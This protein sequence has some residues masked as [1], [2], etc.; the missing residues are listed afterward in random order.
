MNVL[1]IP[2]LLLTAMALA[3]LLVPL[4][5]PVR[6][7]PADRGGLD[8]AVF[9]DQLA[10]V[11]QDLE[12]GLLSPAEAE[13]MRLELQRRLLSAAST[14]GKDGRTGAPARADRGVAAA[15]AVLVP[16]GAFLLYFV[17][18][19]PGMR[20]H[21]LAG[22]ASPDATRQAATMEGAIAKLAKHLETHP[23]NLEGWLL[24]G[25][26]HAS[27]DRFAD[28]AKAYAEARK[29]A[30]NDAD[31][32]VELAEARLIASGEEF[33]REVHDLFVGAVKS[34]PRNTK[35]RFYLGMEMAQ[36]GDAPGALQAWTD[37]V[38][39]SPEEAPWLEIVNARITQLAGESGID[40]STLQPSA[41]ARELRAS[42]PPE[43]PTVEGPDMTPAERT[44]LVRASIGPLEQHLS[45]HPDDREGW[46]RLARA[47]EFLGE[48]DKAGA[49]KAKADALK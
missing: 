5:R 3:F 33:S 8:V 39:L 1:W 12:Q 20:D 4:L 16:A 27:M 30:P 38:A 15:I 42:T 45:R 22:R 32:A 43:D 11:D 26:S 37:L 10:G 14:E 2:F 19:A 44:A 7:V 28:A 40:P 23:E 29:L 34:D 48:A 17:L 21:P 18:G 47:Y 49:A 31:I 35:A 9:R 25:R 46:I 41:E 13:A 6:E 24:L 36:N